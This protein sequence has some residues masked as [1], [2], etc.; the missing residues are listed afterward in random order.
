MV[1]DVSPAQ[2]GKEVFI[3]NC[4]CGVAGCVLF[5]EMTQNP[6]VEGQENAN[7]WEKPHGCQPRHREQ[8]RSVPSQEDFGV[9]QRL[10]EKQCEQMWCERR[11]ES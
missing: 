9:F 4:L 5:E 10:K 3:H 6:T 2:G 8:L 7:P 1:R 11:L